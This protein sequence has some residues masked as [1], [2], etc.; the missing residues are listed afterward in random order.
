MIRN[1]RPGDAVHYRPDHAKFSHF[2]SDEQGRQHTIVRFDVNANDLATITRARKLPRST[3][4]TIRLQ[5]PNYGVITAGP[6][7]LTRA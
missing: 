5:P 7:E 6:K 1:G 2:R 4:Y 3:T